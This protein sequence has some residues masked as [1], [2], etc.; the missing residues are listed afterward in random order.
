VPGAA[1]SAS[2]LWMPSA[3]A[4]FSGPRHPPH[5]RRG[6]TVRPGLGDDRESRGAD[7]VQRDGEVDAEPFRAPVEACLAAQLLST[8][9]AITRVPKPRRVGALVGGP[10]SSHQWSPRPS[11]RSSQNSVTPPPGLESAPYLAALVTSSWSATAIDCA[12]E[13]GSETTGPPV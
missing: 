10:P 7:P 9:A 3:A 5:H 2:L 13:G 1:M 11:G 8:L 4:P 12:V 6:L